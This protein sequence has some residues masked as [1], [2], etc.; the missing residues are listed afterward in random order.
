[1]GDN[2]EGIPS[3][4]ITH[5]KWAKYEKRMTKGKE[6]EMPEDSDTVKSFLH[7]S[8]PLRQLYHIVYNG[9]VG[10]ILIMDI[11]CGFRIIDSRYN[12]VP[13]KFP[14]IDYMV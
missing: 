12:D 5:L 2:N 10:N 8:D 6:L 7:K 11:L 9:D 14:Q 1:M 4:F 13:Y 3:A